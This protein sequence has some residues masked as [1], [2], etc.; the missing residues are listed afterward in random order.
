MS[1]RATDGIERMVMRERAMREWLTRAVEAADRWPP[2][3]AEAY[4]FVDSITP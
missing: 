4:A 3:I 1:S 2:L